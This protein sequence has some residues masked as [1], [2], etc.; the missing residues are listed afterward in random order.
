MGNIDILLATYNGEKFIKEQIDSILNQTY[1]DFNLII[2]DDCSK[3]GTRDILKEYEKKDSRIKVF[4]QSKNLGY[5]KNFEFLLNE[6]ESEYYML[7]DQDDVWLPEKIEKSYNCLIDNKADLVFSDLEV[8]DR[9]LNTTFK[10]FNDLMKYTKKAKKYEDYRLEYLYNCVTGCTL[11]TKSKFLKKILPL[12]N[13]SEYVIHDFWIPLIVSMNG[14]VKYLNEPLIKYRQHGHNQVGAKTKGN[15]YKRFE[16][17]RN[18][19]IQVKT[20]IFE[21]YVKNDRAFPEKLKKLNH[22]SLEYFKDIKTKEKINFKG[23]G[24]FHKLY[25]NDSLYFYMSNFLIFNLPCLGKVIFNL[26]L[27]LKGKNNGK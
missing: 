21:T 14:K 9:K 13:E 5:V 16:D 25:K 8:V 17:M 7:S 26:R 10:S 6:V 15:G 1:Q 11:L 3:D 23:W 22:K 2:S 4:F 24:V 18:H 19:F 12:P 20:E 27:K